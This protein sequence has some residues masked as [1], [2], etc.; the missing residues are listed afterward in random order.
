MA[1]I[2]ETTLTLSAGKGGDGVV[3]WRREKFIPLGG[4]YGGKGGKGGD[5]YI[6]AMPDIT[7]LKRYRTK[8]DF[9]AEDGFPGETAVRTGK[10]GQ[11]LVIG[12]PVGSRV[13][14]REHNEALDLTTK[15]ER[16]LILKGGDGGRGNFY[17]KSSVNRSPQ[18]F[19]YGRPGQE[20]T[21]DIELALIAD[22]GFIGFPNA[23]KTTLLN[24][25]TNAAAKVGA[26]PFTTLEPNLGALGPIILADVPGLI[27][28]ASKGRGL[29]HKFLR[30]ITRT[31]ILVHC[32]A[33][34]DPISLKQRYQAIRAELNDFNEALLEKPEIIV[35]TK[36]DLVTPTQLKAA[37]ASL[38][39]K[40]VKTLVTAAND[41]KTVQAL[42]KLISQN[43]AKTN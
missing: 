22:V 31:R 25:L 13:V 37:K 15:G 29:G 3:R 23:G 42:A 26:Y 32:L 39:V 27:E 6:E 2:D 34:E 8:T 12:L 18:E 33:L 30:H 38:K 28:G 16:L 10:N 17:F 7:Y 1:L 20:G 5:V 11:D 14:F 41:Q 35:L 19:E 43:L 4:P 9:C 40:G 24:A 21:F 36:Q